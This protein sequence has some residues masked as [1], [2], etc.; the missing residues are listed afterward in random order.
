MTKHKFES[1]TSEDLIEKEIPCD[2]CGGKIT[3]SQ[4]DKW[5]MGYPACDSCCVKFRSGD[6]HFVLS[7]SKF[8]KK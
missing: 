1:T 3:K 7:R 6:T 8:Y 2:F 4:E 5:I